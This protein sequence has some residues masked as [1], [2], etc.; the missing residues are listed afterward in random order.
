M[1]AGAVDPWERIVA[2]LVQD[3][4]GGQ[5]IPGTIPAPDN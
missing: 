2:G 3:G 5:A 4:G 1:E